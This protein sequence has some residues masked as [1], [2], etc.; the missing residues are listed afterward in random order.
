MVV[1]KFGFC[2]KGFE[3]KLIKITPLVRRST[4]NANGFSRF[5]FN[6]RR[7][8]QQH[9]DF[10]ISDH[11]MM[12]IDVRQCECAR[13]QGAGVGRR[14]SS[15]TTLPSCSGTLSQAFGVRLDWSGKK[16]WKC[17]L[18]PVILLLIWQSSSI[19]RKLFNYQL[20]TAS[21]HIWVHVVPLAS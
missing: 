18:V 10:Q 7:R 3:S 8:R 2:L 11:D 13:V 15:P 5:N 16:T 17:E 4:Q 12:T 14:A 1:E 19:Y 9:S 20:F 6:R 21:F